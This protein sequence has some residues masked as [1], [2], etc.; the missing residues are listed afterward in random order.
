[1]KPPR[2]IVMLAQ[3]PPPF[4]GQA[5]MTQVLKEALQ[6]EFEVYP[7]RMEFSSTVSENKKLRFSKVWKIFPVLFRTLSLLIRHRGAVLYYPPAPGHWVPVL[8]DLILLGI[9]R[10]FAGKTVFHFHARGLGWFLEQHPRLPRAAWMRPDCAIVLGPSVRRD[11]EVIQAR[12]V[13]EIPYGIARPPFP[14]IGKTGGEVLRILFVGVHIPSKGIF[15]LLKTAAELKRRG[16]RFEMR[17][18]GEWGSEAIRSRFETIKGQLGLSDCVSS[19]GGLQG[20]D[21]WKE[22]A[23]ADVFFFP[24]FYEHETFGV[25]LVEAMSAGLPLVTSDWPGPADVAADPACGFVCPVRDV[26]AYANALQQLAGDPPLRKRAGNAAYAR[27]ERCYVLSKYEESL[28]TCFHFLCD[29]P[30]SI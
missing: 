8:R 18:V 15:D 27:Y 5:V 26:Q 21:V 7:V 11:A 13:A 29:R 19:S 3:T 17:T 20:S 10:P 24:T 4:H 1:M 12:R 25:V 28:K 6:E 2:A 9:C 22:Y 30:D 16:I 23:A 14:D